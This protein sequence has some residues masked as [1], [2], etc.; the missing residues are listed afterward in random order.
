MVMA[1]NLYQHDAPIPAFNLA[2]YLAFY[3][4]NCYENVNDELTFHILK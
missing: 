2:T 1:G 3:K 4:K